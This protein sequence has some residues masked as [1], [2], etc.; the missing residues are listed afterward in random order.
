MTVGVIDTYYSDLVI[1]YFNSPV[2]RVV[3]I[4]VCTAGLSVVMINYK[5]VVIKLGNI[6][7][8][9]RLIPVQCAIGG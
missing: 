6:V 4:L 2:M 8:S 5:A 9:D 7:N 3:C 1:N